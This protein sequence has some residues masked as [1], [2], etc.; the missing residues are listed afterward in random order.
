MTSS[1][2][3]QLFL[4]FFTERGHTAISSSS[5]VPHGD[6]TLLFTTAG[7]VQIKP[8]FLGLQKPPNQRLASC[9]KCFRTT[10][11]DSVGDGTHLTLF[12]MLGNFSV[13]DYFKTEAV[14]WAWEFVTKYLGLA[15]DRLWASV[16]LDDD[17]A[18]ALW[19]GVGIPAE[20]IYRFGDEDNFWGPA[21]DSGPCGPCSELHYDMS[22]ELG[23]GKP[24]CGPNCDCGRFVEIWNLVFTQY[25]QKPDGSRTLLPR[26][27][28]DTG[29]GLERI[30][31]AVQDKK[32]VY[33]TDIFSGL[34]ALASTMTGIKYGQSTDTDRALRIVAEHGRGMCF[35]I[36]DGVLPTND[37]RGYVL[38]RILRRASLFGR[39]IG[40]TRP[41]LTEIAEKVIHDM[42]GPYP[43]LKEHRQLILDVIQAEE[44][45]F[46]STLETGV[47]IVDN[48]ID[49]ALAAK[50]DCLDGADVFRLYDT[51]GFPRELTAEVA[52]ERGLG[53]DVAGFEAALSRQ[54][55]MGRA[56]HSFRA[57]DDLSSVFSGAG[58]T[59]FD[60][61]NSLSSQTTVIGLSSGGISVP[62]V[63]EGA[64]VDIILANTPFYGE[65]GGQ[66]GDTGRIFSDTAEVVVSGTVRTASDITVH[67][68][69]LVRGRIATGDAVTAQVEEGQR[70]DIARNHT[71]THLLQAA[72]REVLGPQVAQRGSLVEPDRFRFDFSWMGAVE[73]EPI[74]RI[75]SF[76]NEQ[77]RADHAVGTDIST[78][79]EAVKEGAIA[80]FDEKYGDSVR[81]VRIGEPAVSTELCG[82]THVSATG[83]IGLFIIT[84]EAS[85]GTGL[86]RIE[87][88]TGRAAEALVRQRTHTLDAI[89]RELGATADDVM[90]RLADVYGELESARKRTAALEKQLSAASVDA[91]TAGATQIE[92]VSVVATLVNGLSLPTL[93][94]MGDTLKN[95]L[96][97]SVIVL[98]SVESDRPSF[99]VMVSQPLTSRGLHAGDIAKRAATITGGGGGG[100]PT[101]AQAGGKDA[102]RVPAA[103][104]EAIRV[105]RE[106]LTSE[107]SK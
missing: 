37:G 17:E 73:P 66:V 29:M 97:D 83:Q 107:D 96:G 100:K 45:R 22:P 20:R 42:S 32:T 104:E 58:P 80:L 46:V 11:V 76:V 102:T 78:L 27:N 93:R 75:Q 99:L 60:G 13:G 36:A 33:E 57:V 67:T 61:Y 89:S 84:S 5:L 52:S 95:R 68:G 47:G 70:A 26:P 56:S 98:A 35:L 10:D 85:V 82:G 91:L 19:E 41:F 21:G 43:E 25:D 94:E 50:K 8:Y 14:A 105:I 79:D 40:L 39:R 77:I 51:Y 55:E 59:T 1:E 3:R 72:L 23:C 86:R 9:Q 34:I 44:K 64:D 31:A 54:Q 53:I 4:D 106:K 48:L 92:G 18:F 65:M 88:V 30:T 16:Y 87:A 28:I 90:E 71:A 74:D 63:D 49:A 2:L 62:S 69:R 103:L 6:P 38:R 12:E 7:M 101:M 15:P 81:V 24:T